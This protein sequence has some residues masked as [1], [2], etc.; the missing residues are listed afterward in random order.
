MRTHLRFLALFAVLGAA[1]FAS[2]Q[3]APP[4]QV[5]V[6]AEG[7]EGYVEE[8][9]VEDGSYTQDQY[10]Q[11]AYQDPTYQGEVTGEPY[12]QQEPERCAPKARLQRRRWS[13][14]MLD[15]YDPGSS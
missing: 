3:D 12:Q 13:R 4:D 11:P 7:E 9:Y 10:A 8:E 5:F 6:D 14:R 2:A 1:S 15:G